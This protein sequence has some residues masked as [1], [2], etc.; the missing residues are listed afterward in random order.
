MNPI[1]SIRFQ[2]VEQVARNTALRKAA[3]A[4][5]MPKLSNDENTAIQNKFVPKRV[6]DMYGADG[7]TQS[8]NTSRG[9]NIDTRV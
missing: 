9:T 7:S 3:A 5:D 4:P 8:V 6:L 1:N 2:Q